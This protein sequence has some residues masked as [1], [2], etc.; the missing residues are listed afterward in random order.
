MD[1]VF[2]TSNKGKVETAK[3]HFKD[4]IN[5]ECF[6]YDIVE[7][8]INDIQVIAEYKVKKAYELVSKPCISLDSGFYI[9]NYPGNPNFPGAFPKRE[10]IN[11]IGIDG[12]LKKMENIEDRYCYFMECLAYYDGHEIKYFYGKSEGYLSYEKRGNNLEN[13]WS[14]LWSIFIPKNHYKTLAEMD[15][16]ERNNRHDDHTSAFDMFN[17][18]FKN[19]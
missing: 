8:D 18:W 15:D 5:L 14:D 2:V 12:L 19:K 11:K 1:I 3:E 17:N 7:P 16:N 13:K 4:S 6:N 10:L 9:P